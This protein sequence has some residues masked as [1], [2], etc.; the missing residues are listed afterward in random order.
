MKTI[1]IEWRINT[2]L[3]II[4]V[5]LTSD[6]FWD[7]E[8][9]NQDFMVA[10]FI[11]YLENIP[12]ILCNTKVNAEGTFLF[13]KASFT[14]TR[15]SNLSLRNTPELDIRMVMLTTNNG[16]INVSYIALLI[17]LREFWKWEAGMNLHIHFIMS[18]H[19]Q[20]SLNYSITF[21]IDICTKFCQAILILVVNFKGRFA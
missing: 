10:Y 3:F 1:D 6:V 18:A 7:I 4:L 19:K 17:F 13:L 14:E 5:W 9:C 8:M 12:H 15:L 21:N 16:P 2:R 20:Q 11:G